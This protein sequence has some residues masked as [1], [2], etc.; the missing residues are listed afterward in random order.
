MKQNKGCCTFLIDEDAVETKYSVFL[1]EL[2]H[3]GIK[4]AITSYRFQVLTQVF[5][6]IQVFWDITQ[7]QLVNSY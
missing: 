1:H 5:M 6:T 2:R 7:F 3:E 4:T